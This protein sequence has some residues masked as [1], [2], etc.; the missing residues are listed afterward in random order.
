MASSNRNT[1]LGYSRT[2]DDP[3]PQFGFAREA[4]GKDP[5]NLGLG[6]LSGDVRQGQPQ[7]RLSRPGFGAPDLQN[8]AGPLADN[9][10]RLPAQAYPTDDFDD[11]YGYGLRSQLT[12]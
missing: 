10:K 6:P 9:F 2:E 5:R 8:D 4:G 12:G 3:D 7:S 1:P 11:G